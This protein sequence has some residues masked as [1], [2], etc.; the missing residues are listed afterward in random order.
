MTLNCATFHPVCALTEDV[1]KSSEIEGEHLDREQVRS[2]IARRLT[3]GFAKKLQNHLHM[4]SL[5]FVHYNFCRIH[6]TLRVTPAMA[7]GFSDTLH[8]LDWIVG[9]IDARAPNPG[10]RGPYRK[11]TKESSD[12]K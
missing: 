6:K 11:R 2:S 3:N 10:P 5:Y 12:S 9:L 8:D 4:L 1:V 7:A